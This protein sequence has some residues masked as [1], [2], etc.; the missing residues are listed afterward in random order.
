MND[1]LPQK[2][3]PHDDFDEELVLTFLALYHSLEQALVRAGY[4]RA[5]YTPGNPQ[6]D[7]GGFARHIAGKFDPDSS[8]ELMGAFCYLLG[9]PGAQEL[10]MELPSPVSDILWLSELV[11][12]VRNRLL[13]WMN[14]AGKPWGNDANVVAALYIIQAWSKLDPQVESLLTHVQ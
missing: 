11:Q 7:W 4:T 8:P 9:E 3:S 13:L 10:R 1:F 5:G 14:F 6:P 2:E 12:E